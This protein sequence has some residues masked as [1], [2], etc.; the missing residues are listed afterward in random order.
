[1]R[2]LLVWL[3]IVALAFVPLM[4]GHSLG[5]FLFCGFLVVVGTIM[6]MRKV[7]R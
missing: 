6:T 3:A 4:W 5:Q 1:M 2:H 7:R